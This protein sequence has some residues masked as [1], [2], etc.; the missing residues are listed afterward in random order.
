MRYEAIAE[1]EVTVNQATSIKEFI[2][3]LQAIIIS[4]EEKRHYMTLIDGL[5][6][7]SLNL[8]QRRH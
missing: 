6:K 5:Q 8:T 7:M 2:F 1:Q 4:E 3:A